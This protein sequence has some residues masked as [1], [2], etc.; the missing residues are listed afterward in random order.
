MLNLAII[1]FTIS[2][3]GFYWTLFGSVTVALIYYVLNLKF[4]N[5]QHIEEKKT[6]I[7]FEVLIAA[8]NEEINLPYTLESLESL[9]KVEEKIDFSVFVGLDHCTDN[10]LEKVLDFK[11]KNKLKLHYFE[12]EGERGKWFI[13]KQ[14]ILKSEADW[15]ALTDCGAVWNQEILRLLYRKFSDDLL[16]CLAPSYLPDKA[17]ILETTYWRMEQFL[18]TIENNSKG[19][20]MVHG[21]TVFYKREI[22]LKAIELLGTKHWINDDVAIPLVIRNHRADLKIEYAA[23]LNHVALVRD[24][25]VVSDVNIELRRRRRI[26]IGNL[27]CVLDIILPSFRIN[28]LISWTSLRLVTKLLW[29]YWIT[30]F[31]LGLLFLLLDQYQVLLDYFKTHSLSLYTLLTLLILSIVAMIKSNYLHRLFMAYISGLQIH[32]AIKALENPKKIVWS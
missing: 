28:K 20:I 32:K 13:I 6:K 21:P 4:L 25:G 5:K 2:F 15:V 29:A 17:G 3:I 27:Q 23:S 16:F 18:R 12:N 9:D 8:Y 22:L 31:G 24:K 10:T 1:F 14:L 7:K 30:F 11:A 19:S 26:L